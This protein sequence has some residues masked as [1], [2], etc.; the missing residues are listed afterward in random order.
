VVPAA[1]CQRHASERRNVP[2]KPSDFS[3][4]VNFRI[5]AQAPPPVP[6]RG[7]FCKPRAA[8]F[9]RTVGFA[10]ERLRPPVEIRATPT[11]GPSSALKSVEPPLSPLPCAVQT[12]VPLKSLWR[13]KGRAHGA[14]QGGFME[15]LMV[16]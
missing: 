7:R 14:V 8:T 6:L 5:P 3:G 15:S 12:W 1:D 11:A 2:A 4:F 9:L 16:G 13:Q 10:P